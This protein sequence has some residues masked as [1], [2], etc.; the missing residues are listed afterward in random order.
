MH[1]RK[2]VGP[3]LLKVDLPRSYNK[4]PMNPQIELFIYKKKIVLSYESFFFFLAINVFQCSDDFVRLLTHS[5]L[6]FI[7]EFE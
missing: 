5:S 4:C 3:K 1:S 6:M 7:K 2:V